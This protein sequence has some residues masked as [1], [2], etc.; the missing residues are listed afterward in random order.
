MTEEALVPATRK[1]KTRLRLAVQRAFWF[2]W[3]AQY[4]DTVLIE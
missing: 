4:P 2:G 1:S 3:Q